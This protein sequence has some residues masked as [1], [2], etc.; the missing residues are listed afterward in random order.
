[1]IFVSLVYA[2]MQ[3]SSTG[4]YVAAWVW[5]SWSPPTQAAHCPSRSGPPP[6]RQIS[7]GPRQLRCWPAAVAPRAC[8]RPPARFGGYR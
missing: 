4:W 2:D 3:P 6:P 5:S 7:T 8:S 1:L